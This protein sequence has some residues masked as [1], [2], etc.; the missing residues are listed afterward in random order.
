MQD[1][2]DLRAR[3]DRLY[4]CAKAKRCVHAAPDAV[5]GFDRSV[6]PICVHILNAAEPPLLKGVKVR[7]W[8]SSAFSFVHYRN[9]SARMIKLIHLLDFRK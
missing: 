1:D 7:V 9:K 8:P 6:A 5:R 2:R 4:V 3:V